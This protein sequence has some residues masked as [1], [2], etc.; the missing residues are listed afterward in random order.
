MV[1][2]LNKILI[3]NTSVNFD[4]C[5]IKKLIKRCIQCETLYSFI[6]RRNCLIFLN[7]IYPQ[8]RTLKV[9]KITHNKTTVVRTSIDITIFTTSFDL[10]T[11]LT[12]KILE[13]L[14]IQLSENTRVI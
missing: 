14:N 10:E 6:T 4:F 5:F 11:I 7:I 12:K 8:I 2:S 9:R 3:I 13:L 1:E